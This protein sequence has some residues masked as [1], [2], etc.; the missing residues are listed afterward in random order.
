MLGPTQ[1]PALERRG[2]GSCSSGEG[3]K[4]KE[5]MKREKET[6]G[7]QEKEKHRDRE[8]LLKATKE[9]NTAPC[10]SWK[11]NTVIKAVYRHMEAVPSYILM[12]SLMSKLF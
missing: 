2:C 4:G 11:S 6:P 9:S 10:R 1:G 12:Q 5:G 7:L 3:E 8:R